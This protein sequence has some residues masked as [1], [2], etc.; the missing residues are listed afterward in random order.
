MIKERQV[1]G[2]SGIHEMEF[3]KSR[4]QILKMSNRKD[5]DD[6]CDL[7]FDNN[8]NKDSSN[9]QAWEYEL[10]EYHKRKRLEK[11]LVFTSILSIL[12]FVGCAFLYVSIYILGK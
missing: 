6:G 10:D 4:M 1:K 8:H 7:T 3:E 5:E 11:Y 2:N 9:K 12:G